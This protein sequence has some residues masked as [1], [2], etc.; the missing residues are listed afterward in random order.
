MEINGAS[1][2]DVI[3]RFAEKADDVPSVT[4]FD[5]VINWNK[6]D[7]ISYTSALSVA[8]HSGA[9]LQGL[10]SFNALTGAALFD[11]ND[12]TITKQLIAV[13]KS[14]STASNHNAGHVAIWANGHNTEI[15]IR[16][17]HVG[18]TL[19]KGDELIQLVGVTPDHVNLVN[20]VIH[21]I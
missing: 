5:A 2:T 10:A 15:L 13:E 6:H 14:M 17:N 8:G 16:D 7:T 3:I 9:A 18:D 12:N 4:D 20:G 19:S 11:V 21:Y 1:N